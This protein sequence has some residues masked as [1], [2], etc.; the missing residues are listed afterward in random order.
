MRVLQ[1]DAENPHP[2]PFREEAG[3]L[4]GKGIAAERFRNRGNSNAGE[5]GRRGGDA[6]AQRAATDRRRQLLGIITVGYRPVTICLS[7]KPARDWHAACSVLSRSMA[8]T[9]VVG[10][11]GVDID[12]RI[13]FQ[14][15]P[16]DCRYRP[17]EN[18]ENFPSFSILP[19]QQDAMIEISLGR[20]DEW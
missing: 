13:M 6:S 15:S 5:V 8:S 2:C 9:K 7:M 19:N 14:V 17:G 16:I 18:S 4:E 1:I 12:Q 3:V 20:R 10:N 11:I